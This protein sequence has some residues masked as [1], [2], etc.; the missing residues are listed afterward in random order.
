[1]TLPIRNLL[2][3][4]LVLLALLAIALPAAA[5]K[6]GISRGEYRAQG[7]TLHADLTFARPELAATVPGLDAN[8]DG[9]VSENE[10]ASGK[11][12]LVATVVDGLDVD[13]GSGR[14]R[15]D[16]EHAELTANDGLA[17][18]LVYACDKA[19]AA[20]H[21]RMPLLASLSVGHRHLADVASATGAPPVTH[22]LYEAS[23]AFDVGA[24][25]AQA[26]GQLAGSLFLLG[27]EHILTGFDHLMFLFGVVLVAARLRTILLAVTA[28]TLAHSVTLGLATLGFWAPSPAIVEPAIALSIVY[29]GIENWFVKDASRRWM[30]TFPFGLVHGF[31]FAGALKEIAL[32]RSEVPLALVSFNLGVE[33][34]QVLVLALVL[35][36]LF[37]LRR[38]PWFARNGVRSA[39]SVVALSG[40]VWF[41]Q[42]VAV[43]M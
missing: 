2:A 31:G 7:A 3:R 1:M 11:A 41:V 29:V 27:I 22:V 4:C 37:W 33:A 39:S 13:A 10:L 25:P 43:A 38:L 14:C 40:L 24:Q 18:H 5:H 19:P 28:F 17:L 34:G 30:L 23:P 35:P 8:G 15:G 32:P 36:I 16:L 21:L 20:F 12:A 42:R 9:T 6:V 26:G